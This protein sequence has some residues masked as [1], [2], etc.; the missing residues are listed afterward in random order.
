MDLNAPAEPKAKKAK[1]KPA[2]MKR[3][4]SV[5]IKQRPAS[6]TK[7]VS[8]AWQGFS[9]EVKIK[10]KANQ[11]LEIVANEMIEVE[12][13]GIAGATV[14]GNQVRSRI[15]RKFE[16]RLKMHG[17]FGDPAAMTLSIMPYIKK[18]W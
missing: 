7:Q 17:V 8:T 9:D 2:A 1:K 12:S 3:P 13:L 4:L 10:G 11:D 18:R 16:S 14:N 5:S 6:P 15:Y